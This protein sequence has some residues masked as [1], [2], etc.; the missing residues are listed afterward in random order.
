[1]QYL[2]DWQL[3]CFYPYV[4]YYANSFEV[5][6]RQK[7]IL[8]QVSAKVPGSVQKALID[9]GILE[10]PY[11]EMNSLKAEWV[12]NKWW[13]YSIVFQAQG[14]KKY[15]LVFES[16]D[17]RA[18]IFLNGSLCGE[19]ENMFVPLVIEAEKY[20][21]EGENL[22]LVVLEGAPSETAQLGY[23]EQ[24]HTQKSRFTYKWDFCTRL[25]HLG[26]PGKVYLRER[27]PTEFE[28]LIFHGNKNGNYSLEFN[29]KTISEQKI[30]VK[31][32]LSDRCDRILYEY[33]E[34][35]EVKN[36]DKVRLEGKIDAIEPWYPRGYGEQ[37]LYKLTVTVA[38]DFSQSRYVGFKYVFAEKNRPGSDCPY[39][40]WL[41]VN[42][43]S[44]YIKGVNLTPL[45]MLYGDIEDERYEKLLKL[46]KEANVNLIRVWGG[47]RIESELFYELADRYG[48]M[49][50]QEFPQSGAGISS[51][52]PTQPQ[53]LQNLKRTA[54]EA[55]YKA[56]HVSLVAFSGG[57]ELSDGNIPV[58]FSHEN[59]A[60]LKSV[61]EEVCPWVLMYPTS[62]AGG[63]PM[64]DLAHKGKLFDV[65]GPWQYYGDNHYRLYNESDS[66]LHSEF[67]CD[68]MTNM[69]IF[70]K[71]FA[72]EN[73]K[74]SNM[75][76]N[77]VWRH[78]GEW[79]DTY[80]RDTAIFYPP[81]TLAEQI[82]VSQFMQAEG[83]RYAVEANRRRA[84]ENS[85]SI[86]WQA[87]EPY[88]NASCTC[89]IDY[90][91]QPKFV[92]YAVRQAFCK[93]NPSLAYDTFVHAPGDT[94]RAEL[95]VT[96]DG[97]TRTYLCRCEIY[98]DGYL[99]EEFGKEVTVGGGY[100]ERVSELNIVVP[101]CDA[102][103][104]KMTVIYNEEKY[105]NSVMFPIKNGDRANV[106]PVIDFVKENSNQ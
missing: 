99:S 34:M 5:G 15:D 41:K 95:F 74:V 30:P 100:T 55:V 22:L 93:V 19:S 42:G 62:G 59:I 57:N 48:I 70:E 13:I 7:S 31:V 12:E 75:M 36:G 43:Q 45:D 90:F 32:M 73:Q 78:H 89:L 102:V 51:L 38:E 60:M 67:G 49:V 68:G 6:I 23:S 88:P 10:D 20:I 21:K 16:I 40:Y 83:L 3:S 81:Q 4:P 26:I 96:A 103:T 47:G 2:T 77:F 86:I 65:H 87:N 69:H 46:L 28:K 1:M 25:V 80:R 17:Y 97:G 56:N 11:Y 71:Y 63:W 35:R 39:P 52:P 94:L 64:C 91:N 72:P 9:A 76:D 14:D 82:A 98:V 18:K 106:S 33:S 37:N 8:P 27:K 54:Q 53:Y 44:I 61:V 79:W 85:G 58:D 50:W 105:I 84:Y 24:T 66:M 101:K 29:I 104:V 92:Y